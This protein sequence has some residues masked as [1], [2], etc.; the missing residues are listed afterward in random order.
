[1]K[2]MTGFLVA[3]SLVVLAGCG[4]R[5]ESSAADAS[6][7]EAPTAAGLTEALGV[8]ALD[9]EIEAIRSALKGGL[10]VN[11]QDSN[12]LTMLMMAGFNGHAEL[13]RLLLDAGADINQTESIGRT[14][15]MLASTGPSVETVKLLL[16]S[17]AKVNMTDNHE[18]WTAL[19]MAAAEGQT[20]VVNLLLANGADVTMK[21][22]DGEDSAYFARQRGFEALAQMLEKLAE[23]K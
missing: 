5:T 23:S 3:L 10:D 11:A 7:V 12:G 1:M 21:D 17:G 8:S 4:K 19:M 22:T 2:W 6:A 18:D 13:V 20:E 14:A 9:G 16:D 15:L